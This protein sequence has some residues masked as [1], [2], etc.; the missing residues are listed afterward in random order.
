MLTR[1]SCISGCCIFVLV[2]IK[3][4]TFGSI[5]QNE[6]VTNTAYPGNL[7]VANYLPLVYPRAVRENSPIIGLLTEKFENAHLRIAT[8]F[9]IV[10]LPVSTAE[11]L[12]VYSFTC[13]LHP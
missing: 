10:M 4:F 7:L 11:R 13:N 9:G 12:L 5:R 1:V 6:L 3:D 2:R 8:T